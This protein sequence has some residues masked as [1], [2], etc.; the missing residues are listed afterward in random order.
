MGLADRAFFNYAGYGGGGPLSVVRS[1]SGARFSVAAPYADRFSP[2]L[3][4]LEASGYAIKPGESGGYNPRNIAGTNTPSMHASG[5]AI[6]VNW[7]DNELGTRGT[8]DPTLARNL[9]AKHGLTWG[10]D[11]KSKLDPMHFEVA[12]RAPL[13]K[14]LPTPAGSYGEGDWLDPG[15]PLPQ[16]QPQPTTAVAGSTQRAQ[17]MQTGLAAAAPQPMP[18]QQSGGLGAYLNDV[19]YSPLFMMGANVLGARNVGEGMSKGLGQASE[20]AL[21]RLKAG[22]MQ[23]ELNRSRQ[24]QALWNNLFQNGQANTSHPLLRNVPEDLTAVVGAM[25]PRDGLEALQ[26]FAL[27]K[28][29]KSFDKVA[30]EADLDLKRA[31]AE[32]YRAA[33]AAKQPTQDQGGP[34]GRG[35]GMNENGQLVLLD[36]NNTRSEV[37]GASATI[38]NMART[39]RLDDN[40]DLVLVGGNGQDTVVDPGSLDERTRRAIADHKAIAAELGMR[41]KSGHIFVRKP[42]GGVGQEKLETIAP[43]KPGAPTSGMSQQSIERFRSAMEDHQAIM[44][45]TGQK[46]KVGHIWARNADGTVYQKKMMELEDKAINPQVI[47]QSIRNLKDSFKVLVGGVNDA[48]ELKND[49]PWMATQ[50]LSQATGGRVSP[51][52]AQAYKSTEHA[53]MNLSYALSGKTVGQAEQKRILGM[54]LPSITDSPEMKAYKINAAHELF[55]N[56]AAAR[57]RGAS[58]DQLSAMFD[59]ALAKAASGVPGRA[60]Y[61]SF[62]DQPAARSA[63]AA[64]GGWS[65]KR[66]D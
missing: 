31:H 7:N 23:D 28:S 29:I 16:A 32:Y 2:F 22:S 55:N 15:S 38:P 63:P 26:R 50:G 24:Q 59:S 42:E 14:D 51:E 21:Q 10:G 30:S 60:G 58:D 48:G 37:A 54:Y 6:D 65:I 46:P 53:I 4:D 61:G 62:R 64:G 19:M 35:V 47:D 9:S 56:L 49:G 1:P 66:V 36:S 3:R 45:H 20:A 40:G 43:D 17:P 12:P 13:M 27:T 18:Q 52:I 5:R 57:K 25:G 44:A 11:W 34:A 41:P 39:H 33:A 8:I